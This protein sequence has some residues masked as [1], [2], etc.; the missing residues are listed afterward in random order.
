MKQWFETKLTI[1]AFPYLVN[2]E[3]DAE[4]FDIIINV[5]DEFHYSQYWLTPNLKCFWF[6]MN[7][8][9]K[10]IG[11]NSIYGSMVILK[12]A[13]FLNKRVYLHCHS[14]VNRSRAVQAAYYYMRVGTQYKPTTRRN[15]YENA[16]VAMCSRGY[17][18]PKKEME[19]F[20]TILG[21]KI[22]EGVVKG[23]TLDSCKMAAINN[24]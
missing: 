24:F 11:L 14:G 6:P 9:K 12:W 19:S 20:L 4:D 10:D 3:F 22:N 18:P 5:S 8:S 21:D 17:L 2:E 13:E 16:L 1:G 15:N 23:G 7:E